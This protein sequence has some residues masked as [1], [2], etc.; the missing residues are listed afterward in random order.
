MMLW[1]TGHQANLAINTAMAGSFR[2]HFWCRI[3]QGSV[4]RYRCHYTSRLYLVTNV[5][6][7]HARIT[8]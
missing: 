4:R 6:R 8:R 5:P 1:N 3:R 2:H 7:Q